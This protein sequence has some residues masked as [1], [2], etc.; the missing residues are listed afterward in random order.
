MFLC[1]RNNIITVFQATVCPCLTKISVSYD[2]IFIKG[3]STADDAMRDSKYDKQDCEKLAGNKTAEKMSKQV[4][5]INHKE[6]QSASSN[7]CQCELSLS[8]L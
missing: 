5:K 3:E 4:S 1:L 8:S 6:L 2:Q 7:T